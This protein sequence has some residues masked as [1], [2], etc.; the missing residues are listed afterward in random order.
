MR[1]RCL[2]GTL[3]VREQSQGVTVGGLALPDGTHLHGPTRCTVVA[4][5]PGYHTHGGEWF[6][7]DVE[8]GDVVLMSPGAV[9]SLYTHDGEKCLFVERRDVLAVEEAE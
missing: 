7:M 1:I 9:A 6:E 3:L 5:G 8:A 4:S 2:D